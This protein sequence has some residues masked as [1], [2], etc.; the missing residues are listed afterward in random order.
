[1]LVFQRVNLVGS[2]AIE[3]TSGPT[4]WATGHDASGMFFSDFALPGE[5]WKCN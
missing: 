4:T 2:G 3:K 5:M 1:M